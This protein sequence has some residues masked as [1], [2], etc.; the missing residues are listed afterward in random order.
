MG[1]NN[2]SV[3]ALANATVVIDA[4]GQFREL[5]PGEQP[6]PGEVVVV[7]G[8]NSDTA[9]DDGGVP[10]FAA[11]LVGDDGGLTDIDL[12]NEI[13]SIFEQIEQGV[14]PTLND[15]FATAAGGQNGS[16]LTSSGDIERTGTET[17]AETSFET[18][19][20]ESQGL[21]ETQSLALLDLAR[22]H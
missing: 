3:F 6:S 22:S 19:G 1:I 16:S 15:E 18:S 13:A 10:E 14:D 12:E 5:L 9:S 4:N 11:Q 20:L 21:S 7:V 8:D 2:L 17:L